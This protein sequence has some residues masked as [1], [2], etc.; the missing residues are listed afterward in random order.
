LQGK[1]FKNNRQGQKLLS[2]VA[3]EMPQYPLDEA[4]EALLPEELKPYFLRWKD[5]AVPHSSPTRRW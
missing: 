3:M 4:F 1:G 5:S 2:I